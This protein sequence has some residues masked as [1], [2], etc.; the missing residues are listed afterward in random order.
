MKYA[1]ARVSFQYV[2]VCGLNNQIKKDKPLLV[3]LFLFFGGG[4]WSTAT[5]NELPTN[6]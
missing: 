1:F 3:F 6:N 2:C 5:A 4:L